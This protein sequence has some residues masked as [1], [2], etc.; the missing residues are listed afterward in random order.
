MPPLKNEQKERSLKNLF[1]HNIRKNLFNYWYHFHLLSIIYYWNDHRYVL[2]FESGKLSFKSQ[3]NERIYFWNKGF[4]KEVFLYPVNGKWKILDISFILLVLFIPKCSICP[5]TRLVP[6]NTQLHP[7]QTY[8]RA[9]ATAN[10]ILCFL[11]S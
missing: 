8:S 9:D 7:T 1:E 6:V 3:C 5:V 2:S 11:C 4:I 10:Y